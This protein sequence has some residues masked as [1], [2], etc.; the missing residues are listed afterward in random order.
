VLGEAPEFTGTQ[1]WFNSAPLT[2]AGLRGRVV[3]IDFWTYTCINCIRTQPYLKAWDARYR[4]R[5]LTIV[6]VHS[7]EFGFE[8]NAGNVERAIR[9]AGLRYPVVQDNDLKTWQA[10]GNQYWPAEYLV[11]A[12]GRVRHTSFGEG[13]YD[14][15]EHAIRSLL[16]AAGRMARPRDVV[17]PSARTTP[18]TY[19]GAA[20][21]QGFEGTQPQPGTRRYRAIAPAGLSLSRFTLGGTWRVTLEDATAVRDATLTARVRAKDVYLVLSGPGTVT[22]RVDD[23]RPRRVAVR[24]QR[25]YTLASRD[26][27]ANHLVRLRFTPG[28]SAFA[29][30]FG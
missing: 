1:R 9:A 5:G 19:V 17:V 27:D 14:T 13:D 18:E 7:P 24:T 20:R 23:G 16:G 8:K 4:S 11:D 28:V 10:W 30:T 29:F 3:L 26:R 22:V 21:A 2:M 15:T 6:G 25:L 12:E